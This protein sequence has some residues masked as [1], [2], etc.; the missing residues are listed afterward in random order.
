[1]DEPEEEEQAGVDGPQVGHGGDQQED[2]SPGGDAQQHGELRG[3]RPAIQ[4]AADGHGVADD[5]AEHRADARA[6]DL[7]ARDQACEGAAHADVREVHRSEGHRGG[8]DGAEDA[9][10]QQGE[11]RGLPHK[12]QEFPQLRRHADALRPPRPGLLVDAHH[13]RHGH[14]DAHDRHRGEGHP[15]ACEAHDLLARRRG[16]RDEGQRLPDGH[17][18]E[19]DDPEIEAH[20]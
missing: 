14:D 6:D 5:A 4:R 16:H 2:R 8:G 3:E 12:G 13:E 11:E 18:A 20:L 1:M 9:L 17:V 7:E 10:R 19:I 15:P